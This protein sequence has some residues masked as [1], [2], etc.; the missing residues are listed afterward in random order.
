MSHDA[1]RA[2]PRPAPPARGLAANFGPNRLERREPDIAASG[3]IRAMTRRPKEPRSWEADADQVVH[4]LREGLE[5]AKARMTEH[6]EQMEAAGLVGHPPE[7]PE[8]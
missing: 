7:T 5:S 2:A 4:D 8:P 1:P 3:C 6:R